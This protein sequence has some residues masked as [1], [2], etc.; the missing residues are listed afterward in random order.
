MSYSVKMI[1]LAKILGFLILLDSCN[2]ISLYNITLK[3]YK[4]LYKVPIIWETNFI[5]FY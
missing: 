2:N 3:I 1:K 4:F 5:L